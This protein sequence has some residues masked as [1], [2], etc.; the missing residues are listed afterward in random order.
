MKKV[1]F[2]S[3]ILASLGTVAAAQDTGVKI[4][5]YGRFG[6]VYDSTDRFV[7]RTAT[8]ID[9]TTGAEV[10]VPYEAK[11]N[12]TLIHTR[13]RFNIDAKVATDSGVGFG[14][15][16]RVQDSDTGGG[17]FSAAQLYTTYEGLRVEVGN[18]N[19][20][21]DS[22]AL[23]YD[24]EMGLR[25]TS[26]GDSLSDFYA[27]SSYDYQPERK[28]LY[29][30][31]TFAEFSV[32]AS[33]ITPDQIAD[34]DVTEEYSFA[35]AYETD[36]FSVAFAG[37]WDG[38]GIEDNDIWFLGAAYNVNDAAT[39]GINYINE[40]FVTSSDGTYEKDSSTIV[41]YGNYTFDAVTLR[42]YVSHN[43]QDGWDSKTAYGLGADYDL[44]GAKLTGSVQRSYDEETYADFG[45][46]F[47]F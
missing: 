14:G 27:F 22:V 30:A 45:V 9:P 4:G 33:Y 32:L 41:I 40:G 21:L 31:Y 39:I 3:T 5:G 28:G 43:D 7:T 35:A 34:A 42:A 18:A 19:T 25:D 20:A 26:Y 10:E 44:G 11:Q 47:D 37:T 38:A 1:L 24:A 16:I 46:R 15:R 36:M 6:L 12:K 29:A 2:A 23:F 8:E 17:G 13:L